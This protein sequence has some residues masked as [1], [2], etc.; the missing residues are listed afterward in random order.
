MAPVNVMSSSAVTVRVMVSASLTSVAPSTRKSPPSAVTVKVA[1]S[2]AS[3]RP[4]PAPSA[5]ISRS[6]SIVKV[7]ADTSLAAKSPISLPSK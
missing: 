3:R 2:V 6:F 7:R 1:A 4:S 5:S